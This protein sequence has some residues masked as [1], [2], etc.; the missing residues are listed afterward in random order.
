MMVNSPPSALNGAAVTDRLTLPLSSISQSRSAST[1]GKSMF[2]K[3]IE[4]TKENTH[5]LLELIHT[6]VQVTYSPG[7]VLQAW[8][9]EQRA[10]CSFPRQDQSYRLAEAGI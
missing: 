6:L 10:A 8:D 1:L 3:I 7:G 4:E 5:P 2:L 9:R